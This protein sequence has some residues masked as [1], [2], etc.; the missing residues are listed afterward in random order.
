MPNLSPLRNLSPQSSICLI[1]WPIVPARCSLSQQRS[2]STI[3][4]RVLL[5]TRIGRF[6]PAPLY[7]VRFQSSRAPC[8]A[9]NGIT[10]QVCNW[11]DSVQLSD[12]P[13]DVRTKVKYLILDGIACAIVGAKL[14]W[15]KVAVQTVLDIEGPG[16]CTVFGWNKVRASFTSISTRFAGTVNLRQ[17]AH[18]SAQCSPLEW[19]PH[20]RIRAR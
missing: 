11:V 14:P 6:A 2:S 20:S 9:P 12:I 7:N 19:V 17:P 4:S 10:G 15:S 8:S 5:A 16:K 18:K 13:S 1:P 3:M